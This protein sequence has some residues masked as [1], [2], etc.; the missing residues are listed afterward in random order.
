MR[1]SWPPLAKRDLASVI[2]HIARKRGHDKIASN[3]IQKD[4]NLVVDIFV[5]KYGGKWNIPR[6]KSPAVKQQ[7][8][9]ALTKQRDCDLI[10]T[11]PQG[12]KLKSIYQ[13]E[14]GVQGITV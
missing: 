1:L 11:I 3:L 2:A 14:L 9:W 5:R 7:V 13:H 12:Y 4:R 8:D 6:T 10:G